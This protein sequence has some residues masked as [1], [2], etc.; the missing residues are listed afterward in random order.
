MPETVQASAMPALV[1]PYL[2]SV[3]QLVIL[4]ISPER[5]ALVLD[6]FN[7]SNRP[8]KPMRVAAMAR[9]MAAGDFESRNG[10]CIT[11]SRDGLLLNGQHRLSAVIKCG[12]TI[13]ASVILGADPGSMAT[14]DTGAKRTLGDILTIRGHADA[15][16]L[17]CR[18]KWLARLEIGPVAMSSRWPMAETEMLETLRRWPEADPLA[19]PFPLKSLRSISPRPDLTEALMMA[20]WRADSAKALVFWSQV[21]TGL[22]LVRANEPAARLRAAF[23]AAKAKR[24]YIMPPKLQIAII[25]KSWNSH[26]RGKPQGRFRFPDGAPVPKLHGVEL[27]KTWGD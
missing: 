18:L 23:I 8:I 15:R 22:G 11:F 4:D 9:A 27:C 5:A 25:A 13:Q 26:C 19:V 10:E 20:T 12:K 3:Y 1:S 16:R 21:S 7:A 14:I 2:S 6:R 17:A 24:H